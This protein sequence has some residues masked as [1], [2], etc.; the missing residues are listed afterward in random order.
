MG[1]MRNGQIAPTERTKVRRLAERGRYDWDTIYSIL[2]EGLVCHLGFEVDG[3]P[4]VVPTTYVRV[5]D[6]VYVHGAV[7]NFALRTLAA[8]VEVCVTVTLL[9]GLV[10]ARS[11][12]HH[13]MNYRSVM[14]FGRAAP[15]DDDQEKYDAMVAIVEHLVPGRTTDTR[16]PS[17]QELRKTLVVGLPLDECS[18]KVRTGGPLD[19]E[20]DMSFGYWAG[21]LPLS[22]VPGAPIPDLDAE[23]PDYLVRWT[24]T[25]GRV[26]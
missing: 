9:D 1:A 18:A 14:L 13:S 2:D 22:I 15:V 11:A 6:R 7:A 3:R 23:A 5:D 24:P 25:S 8:G 17:P 19:D 21:Q 20:E 16:L 10:L 26:R 4:W 12:F